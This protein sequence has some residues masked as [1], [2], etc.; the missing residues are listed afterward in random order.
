MLKTYGISSIFLMRD[1][2]VSMFWRSRS[3][4]V[5][6][7]S[8]FIHIWGFRNYGDFQQQQYLGRHFVN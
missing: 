7:W 6:D 2:E 3:S 5:E 4:K 8:G 1:V